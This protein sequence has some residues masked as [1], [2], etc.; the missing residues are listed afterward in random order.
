MAA[1]SWNLNPWSPKQKNGKYQTRMTIEWELAS[2]KEND[3]RKTM[4][5][6]Y[7]NC[8]KLNNRKWQMKN[9]TK[10]ICLGGKSCTWTKALEGR[11]A[12]WEALAEDRRYDGPSSLDGILRCHIKLCEALCCGITSVSDV[13]DVFLEWK[14]RNKVRRDA[15]WERKERGCWVIYHSINTGENE[16]GV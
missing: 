6:R 14:N 15:V 9:L 11:K 10:E 16:A 12:L 3:C 7:S 8:T 2:R 5:Q 13:W 1:Q 4:Q